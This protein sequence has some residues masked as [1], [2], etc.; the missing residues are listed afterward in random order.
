MS[1]SHRKSFAVVVIACLSCAYGGWLFLESFVAPAGCCAAAWPLPNPIQAERLLHRQDPDDRDG[2][3]QR[4]GARAVLRARPGDIEAWLRLA[5]ADRLIHG[6]LT[7]EGADAI[8]VS[9]S[10]TPYA[11]PRAV[12]R[13]L[14]VLDNWSAAPGRVKRDALEEIRIIRSDPGELWELRR[15]APGLNDPNGRIAAAL[16]GALPVPGV[17]AP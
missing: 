1:S 12:W 7:A 13:V 6:R 11:G 4:T 10:I 3:R 8:D 5:N 17:I 14:F 9:Y 15:R 2:V 16:F